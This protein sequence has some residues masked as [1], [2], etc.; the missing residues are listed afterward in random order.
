MAKF[1][2]CRV[3][4]KLYKVCINCQSGRT[5]STYNWRRVACSP[6]CGDIYLQR[7]I[8]SRKPKPVE[9]AS[10][11]EEIKEEVKEEVKEEIKETVET[12]PVVKKPHRSKAFSRKKTFDA[13]RNEE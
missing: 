10:Q 11:K 13:D 3:C 6:E 1:A 7:V 8:E 12:E 9:K 5:G 4:G 2:E